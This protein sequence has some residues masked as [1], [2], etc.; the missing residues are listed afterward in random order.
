[1][2][3]TAPSTVGSDYLQKCGVPSERFLYH[4]L[5][6]LAADP[7]ELPQ[8]EAII[9][10]FYR[11]FHDHVQK[12]KWSGDGA[13][14]ATLILKADSFH[15]NALV[16]CLLKDMVSEHISPPVP[17]C[18][19]LLEDNLL[20]S[21]VE[22]VRLL[23]SWFVKKFD[24][25]LEYGQ[26][27]R[28][29]QVASGKKDPKLA[30]NALLLMDKHGYP[31]SRADCASAVLAS[32]DSSAALDVDGAIAMVVY[33]QHKYGLDLV[34]DIGSADRIVETIALDVSCTSRKFE[35]YFFKLVDVK[36][37]HR[38][39]PVPRALALALVLAAG[40]SPLMTEYRLSSLRQEY[41]SLF[42]LGLDVHAHNAFMRAHRA[43]H[44]QTADSRSSSGSAPSSAAA[45]EHVLG[46][47][48]DM[49]A[50]G[51]APD[52]MTYS[53]LLSTMADAGQTHNIDAVID[54]LDA[55]G[56]RPVAQHMRRA[57]VRCIDL[58]DVGSAEKLL[59][60]MKRRAQLVTRRVRKKF[61]T[62]TLDKAAVA[63]PSLE[64]SEADI[65][66]GCGEG[67]SELEDVERA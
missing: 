56:V 24:H 8:A 18:L 4:T 27:A 10:N 49:E 3:T 60:M 22:I 46:A 51:V 15:N 45:Y 43:F 37:T 50:A 9:A 44:E 34:D 2:H 64:D 63:Q 55:T 40:R 58:G 12:Q 42:E 7:R 35:E 25:K 28:M 13:F 20:F 62:A 52:A 5:S 53:I 36:K 26:L 11:I 21:N 59:H 41:C 23:S 57:I 31:V 47:F 14:Y 54:H 29:L 48:N 16:L 38:D 17:L 30:H 6:A 39:T 66:Y 67:E 33:V 32:L 1:M 65:G 19:R 61:T